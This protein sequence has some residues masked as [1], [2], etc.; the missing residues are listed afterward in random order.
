MLALISCSSAF[1]DASFPETIRLVRSMREDELLMEAVRVKSAQQ[2]KANKT[3]KRAACLVNAKYPYLTDAIAWVISSELTDSEVADG[4]AFYRSPVGQKQLAQRFQS[5]RGNSSVGTAVFT[6]EERAAFDRFLKRPAGR[7]LLKDRIAQQKAVMER[8]DE[9]LKLAVD[10]CMYASEPEPEGSIVIR[11]SST[12]TTLPLA[13]PDNACS[14]QQQVTVYPDPKKM[15]TATSI[16]VDCTTPGIGGSLLRY[17]GKVDG[18]SVKW[19]GNRVLE[20]SA[21]KGAAVEWMAR[22]RDFRVQLKEIPAGGKAPQCWSS[23]RQTNPGSKGLDDTQV[24]PF[25]MDYGDA[26]RCLLTRRMETEHLGPGRAW[27]VQFLRVKSSELPFGTSQLVF[28]ENFSTQVHTKSVRLRGAGT[29]SLKLTPGGGV[30]GFHMI[31]APAEDLANK[32]AAG[33]DVTLEVQPA[34]GEAFSLPLTR[35]DFDWAHRNFAS[36]LRAL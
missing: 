20:V 5:V 25:W 19:L 6:A 24:Q 27:V 17:K 12:C 23:S 31:G 9:R 1:A 11:P 21:P 26:N 4:I 29:E 14:V 34:T 22:P 2:L 10:D 33:G 3:D 7:K 28:F 36:C 18:I 16:D 15:G 35:T 32:M 13:S 8:I 30:A